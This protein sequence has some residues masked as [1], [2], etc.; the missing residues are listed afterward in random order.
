MD[1]DDIMDSD[2]FVDSDNNIIDLNDYIMDPNNDFIDSS[3]YIMDSNDDFIGSNNDFIA[4]SSSFARKESMVNH[5]INKCRKISVDNKMHY[6]QKINKKSSN[7][8]IEKSMDTTSISSSTL[9]KHNAS[10]ITN[11]FDKVVILLT[12]IDELHTLLLYALIYKFIDHAKDIINF[13][14]KEFDEPIYYLAFFLNSRFRNV[15]NFTREQAQQISKTLLDY[16]NNEPPFNSIGDLKPQVYWKNI[17]HQ[18][19]ALKILA[20]KIFGIQLHSAGVEQLFS[21][22]TISTLKIISQIN[23]TLAIKVSKTKVTKELVVE[24]KTTNNLDDYDQLFSSNLINE[25]DVELK[26]NNLEEIYLETIQ[27]NLN[28]LESFMKEFINF[29]RFEELILV[30]NKIDKNINQ[31]ERNRKTNRYYVN[32]ELTSIFYQDNRD[33]FILLK[34]N[35]RKQ[36]LAQ[37]LALGSFKKL[38]KEIKEENLFWCSFYYRC[39][40]FC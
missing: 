8:T 37:L 15:A 27:N 24:E 21:H 22:M 33:D 23:L 26:V 31:I 39:Y 5:I 14:A 13:R 12:K 9:E 25:N 4:L 30:P 40:S 17:T 10:L 35:E 7:K 19:G 36:V 1:S 11:Y 16:Y 18:V 28:N 3:D 34:P 32:A 20:L 29:S 2:S 6:L 38:E